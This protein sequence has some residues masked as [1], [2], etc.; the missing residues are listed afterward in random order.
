MELTNITTNTNKS[1]PRYKTRACCDNIPH[2]GM[3]ESLTCACAQFYHSIHKIFQ[4]DVVDSFRGWRLSSKEFARSK[5]RL[6]SEPELKNKICRAH[7]LQHESWLR[8]AIH[9]EIHCARVQ[10]SCLQKCSHSRVNVRAARPPTQNN[11]H[12][13]LAHRLAER[14]DITSNQVGLV[15]YPIF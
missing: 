12:A 15:G 3:R 14:Q 2:A 4:V 13:L 10:H 1:F 7:D 8:Q 11:W 5:L 9:M 6:C